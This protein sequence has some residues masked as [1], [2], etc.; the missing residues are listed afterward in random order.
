MAKQKKP[1]R[2][3]KNC[4][5]LYSDR[6][7]IE[8]CW[9]TEKTTNPEKKACKDFKLGPPLIPKVAGKASK[10]IKFDEDSSSSW[11]FY[12]GKH[13][14]LLLTWDPREWVWTMHQ[15]GLSK[16]GGIVTRKFSPTQEELAF[17]GRVAVIGADRNN[18]YT[19]PGFDDEDVV[20]EDGTVIDKPTV[21]KL[22]P[23]RP[24]RK[25]TDA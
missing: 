11:V 16:A 1:S 17:F 20:D 24:H 10:L 21:V 18:I 22:Y 15:I 14:F 5:Y 13:T 19:S 12:T 4:M 8:G 3:C 9:F 25:K 2:K 7:S 23:I 6:G